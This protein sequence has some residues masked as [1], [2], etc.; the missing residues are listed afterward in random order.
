MNKEYVTWKQVDEFVDDVAA[1]FVAD[2]LLD[3]PPG[4]YGLPRGGLVL[5]V[6]LSHKLDIPLLAAPCD[7]CIIVDDICDS[8]ESL[9]H[10]YDQTSSIHKRGYRIVT[11]YY[12]ITSKVIPSFFRYLKKDSWI[13]FP[14]ECEHSN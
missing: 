8:G 3:K 7:G 9:K 4:V 14:W 5:A 11:M 13:V 10:Y 2:M 1:S 12:N 6:M